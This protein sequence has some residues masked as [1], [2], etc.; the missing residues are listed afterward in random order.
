[1]KFKAITY[2]YL[3]AF[4]TIGAL[5][6]IIVAWR[7]F[8]RHAGRP[9]IYLTNKA[10]SRVAF[11]FPE[12]A[13]GQTVRRRYTL[14]NKT[15][16]EL[17]L[18]SAVS[19]SCTSVLVNKTM[20]P[21]GRSTSAVIAFDSGSLPGPGDYAR[22]FTVSDMRPKRLADQ[23]LLA[24]TFSA[25]VEPGL[26]VGSCTIPFTPGSGK[27]PSSF[28]LISN[29]TAWPMR[30]VVPRVDGS[31]FSVRRTRLLV[32]PGKFGKVRVTLR[33]NLPDFPQTS[34]LRVVGTQQ[35]ARGILRRFSDP[36][37]VCGQ[38]EK[39]LA[40]TPGSL[41]FGPGRFHSG[42]LRAGF[43]FVFEPYLHPRIVAVH[44]RSRSI[45]VIAWSQTGLAILIKPRT[46]AGFIASSVIVTYSGDGVHRL[47]IPIVGEFPAA[48]RA[49]Q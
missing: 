29:A 2:I 27:T 41:I 20:L 13:M 47:T 31:F 15:G 21:P 46:G 10:I 49:G 23:V 8:S 24:G 37:V 44:A 38:P 39:S 11:R 1:M 25:T 16:R 5:V 14:V 42:I 34:T 45:T 33:P 7:R 30:I 43:A 9:P 22:G 36:L 48:I 4:V 32:P 28:A 18:T 17:H 40:V 12:I 3:L 35:E 19:C 6:I 26:G